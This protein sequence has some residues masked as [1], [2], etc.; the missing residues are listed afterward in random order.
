MILVRLT[1]VIDAEPLGSGT[2]KFAQSPD[3]RDLVI[4]VALNRTE[5]QAVEVDRR[6]GLS[7]DDRALD[8]ERLLEGDSQV[9]PL[10]LGLVE[11]LEGGV[12][13]STPRTPGARP[14]RQGGS[15]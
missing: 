11:R 2:L 5:L 9:G 13:N 4:L 12:E 15:A 6:A 1:R 3:E 8:G 10:P 7:V 14:V